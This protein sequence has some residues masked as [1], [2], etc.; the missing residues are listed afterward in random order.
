LNENTLEISFDSVVGIKGIACGENRILK[1]ELLEDYMSVRLTFENAFARENS[2]CLSGVS[3]ITGCEYSVSAEFD[4]NEKGIVTYALKGNSG[5]SIKATLESGVNQLLLS[6]GD[7]VRLEID[8][9]GLAVFTVCGEELKSRISVEAVSQIVAV[10]ERNGVMKLYLDGS[11]HCG[12]PTANIYLK[13][14]T[15][16]CLDKVNAYD[17]ALSFDEV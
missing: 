1:A 7:E 14:G 17:R 11:L 10:R 2:L 4:Y 8:A 6:Q 5:F 9:D 13:G 3:D 16:N 12:R 15:M